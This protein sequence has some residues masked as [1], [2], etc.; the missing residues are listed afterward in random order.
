MVSRLEGCL[1]PNRPSGCSCP[2]EVSSDN[3]WPSY[4][5]VQL[6]LKVL[7]VIASGLV[8]GNPGGDGQ[9]CHERWTASQ[10]WVAVR[11]HRAATL[12]HKSLASEG[13]IDG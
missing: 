2:R 6:L 12:G 7:T 10:S 8:P 13:Q 1:A 9:R 11:A 4:C 3:V 5:F